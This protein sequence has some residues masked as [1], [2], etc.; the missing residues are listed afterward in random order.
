MIKTSCVRSKNAWKKL[1]PRR[2]SS[3]AALSGSGKNSSASSPGRQT[4]TKSSRDGGPRDG[5]YSSS[6]LSATQNGAQ[7]V[8]LVVEKS[9]VFT[10]LLDLAFSQEVRYR[11]T[12]RSRAFD[13]SFSPFQS[14]LT[15]LASM[16]SSVVHQS[17]TSLP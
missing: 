17:R 3:A 6:M 2:S 15:L 14:T 16:T 9:I 1:P 8:S 7:I 5:L 13:A 4:A 11:R 12:C 10:F